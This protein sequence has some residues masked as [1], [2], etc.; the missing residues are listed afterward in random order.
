MKKFRKSVKEIKAEA[1]K[2]FVNLM[3]GARSSGFIETGICDLAEVHRVAQV[4]IKDNYGIES[5][6]LKEEWGDD[7]FN[8][9]KT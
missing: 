9:C 3:I 7:I 5:K 4:H 8:L 1:V 6:S 2:E